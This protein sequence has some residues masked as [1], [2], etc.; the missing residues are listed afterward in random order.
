MEEGVSPSLP[1]KGFS[2]SSE[3]GF[4]GS[5]SVSVSVSFYGGSNFSDASHCISFYLASSVSSTRKPVS[6]RDVAFSDE[7]ASK[8][9]F[10]D[11]STIYAVVIAGYDVAGTSDVS[12]TVYGGFSSDRQGLLHHSLVPLRSDHK[13]HPKT[14]VPLRSGQ[15]A[16]GMGRGVA[17]DALALGE[18]DSSSTADDF[19][20]AGSA[21]SG[22]AVPIF[23]DS[24]RFLRFGVFDKVRLG[25]FRPS[26]VVDGFRIRSST[27][28]WA[29]SGCHGLGGGVSV[30]FIWILI[31]RDQ[32]RSDLR[33]ATVL[34]SDPNKVGL[35]IL[36][37][38]LHTDG[39]CTTIQ[40]MK[41]MTLGAIGGVEPIFWVPFLVNKD[42]VRNGHCVMASAASG[43]AGAPTKYLCSGMINLLGL[44]SENVVGV[45]VLD[46][47]D[48]AFAGASIS[49][50]L[51]RGF[52][53]SDRT[54]SDS[55]APFTNANLSWDPHG[56]GKALP[57]GELSVKLLQ[58]IS[59]RRGTT[60]ARALVSGGSPAFYLLK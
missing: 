46:R 55:N 13:F 7:R 33:L 10:D 60:L 54:G 34:N 43:A 1:R 31:C 20:V 26:H 4:S 48:A 32:F 30:I 14:S 22:S 16:M 58:S 40:G 8:V 15:T 29:G 12:S 51:N 18:D 17:R 21:G 23:V 59:G 38:L 3:L 27:R 35:G 25:V 57:T 44:R 42:L 9:I 39:F 45:L 19:T 41:V 28:W 5:L 37:G 47:R 50:R 52:T 36:F 24:T 11:N 53:R 2:F 49:D 6:N 56:C